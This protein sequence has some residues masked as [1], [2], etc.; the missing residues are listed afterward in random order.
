MMKKIFKIQRRSIVFFSGILVFGSLYGLWSVDFASNGPKEIQFENEQSAFVA[1]E[2]DMQDHN[3]KSKT[4]GRLIKTSGF[5][6]SIWGDYK[7][8]YVIL[9]K[10]KYEDLNKNDFVVY[11]TS[12]KLI[13]HRLRTKT[14][15]GWIAEGDGNRRHDRILVTEKNLVGKVL[16]KTFYRY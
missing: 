11:K 7:K 9:E 10:V 12:K 5:S 14:K 3:E 2:I 1:A 4:Y 16:N 15:K 8:G 13:N 6:N